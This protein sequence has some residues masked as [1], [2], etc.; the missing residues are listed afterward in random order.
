MTNGEEQEKNAAS[1]YCK[2]SNIV[3]PEYYEIYDAFHAGI[4]WQKHRP[5]VKPDKEYYGG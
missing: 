4:E 1:D 2:A 5:K 3:G